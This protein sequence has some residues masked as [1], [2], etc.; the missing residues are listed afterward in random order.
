[1]EEQIDNNN[2]NQKNNGKNIKENK[3]DNILTIPEKCRRCR[4]NPPEIMCKEC[5]P[6]IYFCLNCNTNL[7]SMQSK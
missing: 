4:S 2:I 1:M 5:Y 3:Y 7:H 6:F